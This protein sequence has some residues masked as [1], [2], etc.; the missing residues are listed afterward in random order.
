MLLN[1]L[2]Q[3]QKQELQHE[4][5]SAT[6]SINRKHKVFEG[7]FPG[8]P[9][10]PGVCMLQLV[11]ELTEQGLG[12]KF[13]IKNVDNM[14]F[15]SVIDPDKNNLIDINIT[16]TTQPDGLTVSATLFAGE[17]TFFKLV[18]GILQEEH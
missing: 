10:L 14:K 4:S 9:V 15:L 5:I 2:Y 6:V 16:Y 17:L 11:R 3:I 7:H 1:D 18:K 8:Q 12:K 13:S